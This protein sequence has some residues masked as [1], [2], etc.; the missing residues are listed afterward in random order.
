M[1]NKFEFTAFKKHLVQH[2]VIGLLSLF[3]LTFS[4]EWSDFKTKQTLSDIDRFP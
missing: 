2:L 1:S 4:T 3:H